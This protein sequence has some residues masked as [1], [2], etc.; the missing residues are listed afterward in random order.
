LPTAD[1]LKAHSCLLSS[2]TETSDEC[3]TSTSSSLHNV[4]VDANEFKQLSRSIE[5]CFVKSNNNEQEN[6]NGKYNL[7]EFSQE[8][9]NKQL[10][11]LTINKTRASN[12]LCVDELS[13]SESTAKKCKVCFATFE[14]D[15]EL[16]IHLY[17]NHARHKTGPK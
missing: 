10:S 17:Q 12:E 8:S 15:K 11:N 14:T 4:E 9:N 13:Q 6:M 2:A 3:T 16:I 1:T 5:N 7:Q